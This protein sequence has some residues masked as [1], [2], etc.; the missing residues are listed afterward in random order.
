MTTRSI[1]DRARA[2]QKA[3][4]IPYMEA[5][6]RI[7]TQMRD[8]PVPYVAS[9]LTAQDRWA[10]SSDHRLEFHP[11]HQ[12]PTVTVVSPD[13]SPFGIHTCRPTAEPDNA[14]DHPTQ[15]NT[16]LALGLGVD[17]ICPTCDGTGHDQTD[18]S[19]CEFCHGCGCRNLNN[20]NAHPDDH[21]ILEAIRS[22]TI[23]NRSTDMGSVVVVAADIRRWA[24]QQATTIQ[25]STGNIADPVPFPIHVLPGGH[26]LEQD[27]WQGEKLT[28]IGF[29]TPGSGRTISLF[30]DDWEQDPHKAVG[31]Y[32]V[33]ADT[34]G[35]LA[36][37]EVPVTTIAI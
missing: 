3:E 7:E 11:G 13:G 29:E 16:V 20:P 8:V 5:R 10:I 2:L 36:A 26:V 32:P 27:L 9:T 22:G 14:W 6:R 25:Q 15:A 30:R 4:N 33:F 28:L 23:P 35:H 12:Y 1:K 19:P 21:G 34:N 31:M 17:G 24:Y 18:N 37:Y